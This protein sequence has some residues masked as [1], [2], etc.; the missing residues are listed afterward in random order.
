MPVIVLTAYLEEGDKEKLIAQGANSCILKPV[1]LD[2]ILNAL[3]KY[4]SV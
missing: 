3:R 2:E 1:N 4:S